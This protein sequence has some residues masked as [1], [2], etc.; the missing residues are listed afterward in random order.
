MCQI[1]SLTR[2]PGGHGC[3]CGCCLLESFRYRH[4]RFNT[5]HHRDAL[6][7]CNRVF[8]FTRFCTQRYDRSGI[9][10][11]LNLCVIQQNECAQPT[12]GYIPGDDFA[13]WCVILELLDTRR[14][15]HSKRMC[16]CTLRDVHKK[17]SK[18]HECTRTCPASTLGN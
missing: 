16:V 8:K 6:V 2:A 14:A 11:E 10:L 15:V 18:H 5:V 4:R 12:F 3:T 17:L 1:D 9:Q 7:A 13:A